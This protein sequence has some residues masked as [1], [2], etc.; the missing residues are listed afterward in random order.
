MPTGCPVPAIMSFDGDLVVLQIVVTAQ[1][2]SFDEGSSYH[3]RLALCCRPCGAPT[4][5]RRAQPE[6]AAAAGCL[7]VGRG[8]G[9]CRPKPGY[10]RFRPREREVGRVDEA[11]NP[12]VQAQLRGPTGW[13][14]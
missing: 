7:A 5:R 12:P 2:E 8:G 13:R 14:Q 6:H 9:E 4:S 3:D 10:I 11:R 1:L